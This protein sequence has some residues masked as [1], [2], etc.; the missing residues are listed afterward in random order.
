MARSIVLSNGSLLVGLDRNG[1]VRDFYYPHVG[2]A[3]HVSGAS[4]SY[5]HRVG[6]WC[7]GGI[8]WI[9]EPDWVVTVHMPTTD[10]KSTIEAVHTGL[11][12]T[13]LFEDVVHNEHDVFI[14]VVRIRNHRDETREVRIFFGQEFRISESQRGDTAFYDPRVSAIVHYKGNKTFLI[15]TLREGKSFD[16]YTVGIFGIEG[17]EGSYADASDGAL[18]KNPIEHGSVDSIVAVHIPLKAKGESMLHYWVV[19]AHSIEAA[20]VLNEQVLEETP[21]RLVTSTERYWSAWSERGMHDLKAVEIPLRELYRHSLSVIKNHT[22]HDG[23]IIASSDTEILNQG[24]DTYSYVWPRDSALSA[25]ALSRGGYLDVAERYFTFM[26]ARLESGGYLMHKYRVDGVLGSSWHPWVREGKPELP[27]Q[28]DETA[29]VIYALG[30]HF[31]LSKNIEFIESLYNSF[32]EPASDFLAGYIHHETGL[33]LGSYDLWEEKYGT[34]TY[35]AASVYGALMHASTFSG[36]LG[37]RG[38]ALKYRTKA[39]HIARGIHDY[40]YDPH[41]GVYAK[42]IRHTDHG[43]HEVDGTIDM[44][45]AHG[46]RMFGVAPAHD[47]R[48]HEAFVKAAHTLT[49]HDGIGGAVRY[50]HDNYYRVCKDESP[51]PW[52]ITTLWIAQEHIRVA[53]TRD[54]LAPAHEILEWVR[55]YA[56]PSGMLSE[57]LHPKNGAHLSTSPL[58]WSHAEFVHTVYLYDRAYRSLRV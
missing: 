19:V 49:V 8:H 5:M 4:G 1:L 47:L 46:V 26:A 41:R 55:S 14:R 6:V 3:N 43:I 42:L 7:D 50:E 9:H 2:H 13:L 24:R 35:T 25:L 45:S 32:I 48:S 34:S 38:N 11:G 23:G 51:N 57:Q 18:S 56:S 30:E 54:D 33:P 37:K 31:E 39:E 21:E 12:L 40:L 17:K 10:E 36:L 53:R 28:E 20:H 15:R 16:D 27:I 58:V 29:L 22:D 52:I 44:S